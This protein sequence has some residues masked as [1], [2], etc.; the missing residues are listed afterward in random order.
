[1]ATGSQPAT[2]AAPAAPGPFAG[3]WLALPVVLVAMFMAQFDLYVVNVSLPL[4]Q[5]ELHAG[6]AALQ[7]IV[8]GYAFMYATGLITGGRLGDMYGHRRMFVIGAIAFAVASLL[9]GLSQTAGELV[10]FRLLQGLTAAAMVPQVLATIG[11]IFPPAERPRALSWLG[12]TMGVG[13]VAGQVLGGVLLDVNLAGLSWRPIFLVNV[14]IALVAAWLAGRLLPESEAAARPKLDLVGTVAISAGLA[15]ILVPLSLGRSVHWASWTWAC[16]AIS[17]LIL[18]FAILWERRLLRADGQPFLDLRLFQDRAFNLGIIA[19]VAAFGAFFSLLFTLT[20]LLQSGMGLSPL[21]AGLTF[22]PLGVAFA[23]ASIMART[24]VARFGPRMITVGLLIV[25]LGLAALF[26]AVHLGGSSTTV[27]DVIVPMAVIGLG[28]GMSVPSLIGATLAAIRVK[29]AGAAA[30]VL[31]T[32][33]QFASAAGVAGLGSVL[34]AALGSGTG[35]G[36]FAGAI[37]WTAGASLVL[38][39]IA[40]LITTRLRTAAAK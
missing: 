37:Q 2:I 14:P 8:G 20:L 12:V 16:F 24:L 25:C 7:L 11:V 5:H 4:L 31:T 9:A 3:R 1:M 21:Q 18:A 36:A 30:G 34:F 35:V 28:N 15:L 39:A 38:A 23:A 29:Q 33:Q 26:V 22:A 13:A 27:G 19:N 32:A 40:A 17:P 6:E 10:A